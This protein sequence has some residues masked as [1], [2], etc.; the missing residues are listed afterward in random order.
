MVARCIYWCRVAIATLAIG[1]FLQRKLQV[2]KFVRTQI[3][4]FFF[5]IYLYTQSGVYTDIFNPT[6]TNT[7]FIL[8][9]PLPFHTCITLLTTQTFASHNVSIFIYLLISTI[10]ITLLCR[11]K[12]AQQASIAI[13][14]RNGLQVQSLADS[15]NWDFGGRAPIPP[16]GKSC[17]PCLKCL[18]K[19]YGLQ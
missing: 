15:G 12:L 19:Q 10:C 14:E 4:F 8:A 11:K 5:F 3:G 2:G 17:L 18:C 1:F 7:R 13:L 6:S 16:T 9:L